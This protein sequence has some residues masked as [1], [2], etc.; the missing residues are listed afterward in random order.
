MLPFLSTKV[1][2][3]KC[4]EVVILDLWTTF[5]NMKSIVSAKRKEAS[6]VHET[7]RP[8]FEIMVN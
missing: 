2:L 1:N 5:F 4:P 6:T 8:Y 3:A 7:T